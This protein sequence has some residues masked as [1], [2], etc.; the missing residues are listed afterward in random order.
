MRIV[1]SA[2]SM[3]LVSLL[4]LKFKVL[5][6]SGIILIN[7]SILSAIRMEYERDS[8]RKNLVESRKSAPAGR[9]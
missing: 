2:G 3:K 1:R 8:G 6:F 7:R 4:V 5:N 9:Y